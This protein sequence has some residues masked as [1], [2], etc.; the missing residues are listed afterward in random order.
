VKKLPPTKLDNLD[1]SFGIFSNISRP[2]PSGIELAKR[3]VVLPQWIEAC[4]GNREL[5]N[6]GSHDRLLVVHP[7]GIMVAW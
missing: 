6:S 1:S 4:T 3:A 5:A 7:V 2:L